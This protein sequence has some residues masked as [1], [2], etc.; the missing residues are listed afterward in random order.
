MTD[1]FPCQRW[2]AVRPDL[3]NRRIDVNLHKCECTGFYSV[4]YRDDTG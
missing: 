3:S 4:R 1:I 2:M